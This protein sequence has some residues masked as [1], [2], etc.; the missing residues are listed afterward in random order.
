MQTPTL[1]NSMMSYLVNIVNTCFTTE[2]IKKICKAVLIILGYLEIVLPLGERSGQDWLCLNR[3]DDGLGE[4]SDPRAPL[5]DS[6]DLIL[7][8][9]RG[10]FLLQVGF[11]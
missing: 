6:L 5:H 2:H 7:Q 4:E 3:L 11:L 10:L 1:E 8:Q 9:L